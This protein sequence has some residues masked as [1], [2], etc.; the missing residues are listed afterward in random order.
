M[1]SPTPTKPIK[2]LPPV[3]HTGILGW[4]RQNLF[5]NIPNTI[6]TFL[7]LAILIWLVPGLFNWAIGSAVFTNDLQ[8][9]RE[10][11]GTAACWG[12]IHEKFRLILFGRYTYSQQW[13]PLLATLL[14]ILMLGLSCRKAF[15]HW[16]IHPLWLLTFTIYFVLM[17]GF[18][19]S[20][21]LPFVETAKWG[22]LPLTV[23]LTTVGIG[24]SFPISILLALG[25]QSNMPV[26]KSLCIVY[27]EFIRG[28]PLISV[29]FLA[30]FM[31][32]LFFSSGV[33][34]SALLR[35]Q[36]GIVLFSAAYLAETVRGG[37]QGIPN[38]QLEAAQ[39]LGLGYWRTMYFIILPQALRIVIPPLV[40]SFIATL[41][42]TSLV[43]I[44][45]LAELLGSLKMAYSDAQWRAFHIEGYIFVSLV[46]FSVCFPMSRFSQYLE[47]SLNK[48]LRK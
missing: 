32:P 20:Q 2:I 9:C 27:I 3:I 10:V 29:L 36:I 22:G 46:Y 30:S 17:F 12:V 16:W 31:L 8:A 24:L 35:V 33:T 6:I 15:W 19:G 47:K 44:V 38:G 23:L 42:D 40:N 48:D 4:M 14:I 39:S 18:E 1:I 25:R 11:M 28:I 41:K 45:G 34:V 21:T 5:N 13:R 7:I 26:I 43:T 37:L